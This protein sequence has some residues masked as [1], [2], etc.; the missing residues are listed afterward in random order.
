MFLKV[1]FVVEWAIKQTVYWKLQNDGIRR[2]LGGLGIQ[3]HKRSE[4]STS[5][6]SIET[7]CC[8]CCSNG[9][10]PSK[11][12]TRMADTELEKSKSKRGGKP[13]QFDDRFVEIYF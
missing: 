1:F 9:Y 12:M 5:K 7:I 2:G 6:I 8:C 13:N 4:I 10:K 11:C 3:F